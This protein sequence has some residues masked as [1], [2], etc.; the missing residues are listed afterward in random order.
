MK[1]RVILVITSRVIV[2]IAMLTT[3]TRYCTVTNIIT[4]G[5]SFVLLVFGFVDGVVVDFIA[6]N[7]GDGFFLVFVVMFVFVVIVVVIVAFVQRLSL[8]FHSSILKPYFDLS[9]QTK[10]KKICD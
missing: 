1:F 2:I 9:E 7:G 4:I 10:R 8:V 6:V 3:Y 5:W